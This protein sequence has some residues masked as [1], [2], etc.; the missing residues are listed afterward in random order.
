MNATIKNSKNR[1]IDVQTKLNIYKLPNNNLQIVYKNK[2]ETTTSFIRNHN[3]LLQQLLLLNIKVKHSNLLKKINHGGCGLFAYYA[4]N[5][6]HELAKTD[7]K[8]SSIKIVP[9]MS[10]LN[11]FY[12]KQEA[13]DKKNIT[14]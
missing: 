13:I 3:K 7:N 10:D 2:N 11:G 1:N 12:K 9:A 5:K 8:I 14:L 6:L 4:Y